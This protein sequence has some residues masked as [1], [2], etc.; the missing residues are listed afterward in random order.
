MN[1]ELIL[2]RVFDVAV[3]AKTRLHIR[4][5]SLYLSKTLQPSGTL[6]TMQA[7]ALAQRVFFVWKR[8][9]MTRVSS[10]IR[11]RVRNDDTPILN[12]IVV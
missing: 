4:S 1:K 6:V 12:F 10:W 9:K 7:I 5:V 11:K 2:E 8:Q 3:H